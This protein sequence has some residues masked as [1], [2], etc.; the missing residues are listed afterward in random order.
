MNLDSLH[1]KF[2]EGQVENH[3]LGFE[4]AASHGFGIGTVNDAE[5]QAATVGVFGAEV[6][7]DLGVS[8]AEEIVVGVEHLVFVLGF[9]DQRIFGARYEGDIGNAVAIEI[10]A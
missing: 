2:L 7:G 5:H 9:V 3:K 1:G 4:V 6:A 10:T 8:D